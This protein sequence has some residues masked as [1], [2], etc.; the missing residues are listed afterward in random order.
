MAEIKE[1][2]AKIAPPK[3]KKVEAPEHTSKLGSEDMKALQFRIPAKLHQEL[4]IYATEQNKSMTELFS[5]MYHQYREL[6]D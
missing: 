1:R 5:D 3:K 4:K 2:M 6:N